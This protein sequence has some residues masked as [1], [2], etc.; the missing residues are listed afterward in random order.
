MKNKNVLALPVV[1]DGKV[2]AT[3]SASDLRGMSQA[4][5][6]RLEC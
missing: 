2:I 1:S 6:F 4:S 3:L 5:D